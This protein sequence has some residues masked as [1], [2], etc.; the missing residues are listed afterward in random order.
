[1]TCLGQKL[2]DCRTVLNSDEQNIT[3]F[4]CR[5]FHSCVLKINYV[6]ESE[7][8]D[9]G[10]H[11]CITSVSGVFD[12][13][14]VAGTVHNTTGHRF[15]TA[16]GVHG[17]ENFSRETMNTN[18]RNSLVDET[19]QVVAFDAVTRRRLAADG[20]FRRGLFGRRHLQC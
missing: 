18:R 20:R 12:S 4:V 16:L 11:V 2:G 1:M 13:V 10:I 3:L 8:R 9:T 17:D 19:I 6:T 15:T 5:R 14:V 7:I